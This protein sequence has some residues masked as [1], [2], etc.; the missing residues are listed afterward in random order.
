ML[1]N[2][3]LTSSRSGEQE[4]ITFNAM[5][6]STKYHDNEKEREC[7]T[8]SLHNSTNLSKKKRKTRKNRRRTSSKI[9]VVNRYK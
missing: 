1:M 8:F 6:D 2:F 9:R 3:R 7:D 4:L 5:F